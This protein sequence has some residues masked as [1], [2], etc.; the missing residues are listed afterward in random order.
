MSEKI[1]RNPVNT[2][3]HRFMLERNVASIP[4]MHFARMR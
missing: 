3:I 1:A 4:H 2:R